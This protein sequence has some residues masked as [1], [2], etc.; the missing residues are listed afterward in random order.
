[1]YTTTPDA[2]NANAARYFAG[3]SV[4]MGVTDKKIETPNVMIGTIRGTLYG[5]GMFGC[6]LRSTSK[7]TTADP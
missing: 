2:I 1:M 6:V 5:R 7:H 4:T 3:G